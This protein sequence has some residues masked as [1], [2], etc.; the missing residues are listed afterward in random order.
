MKEQLAGSDR[1]AL[2]SLIPLASALGVGTMFALFFGSRKRTAYAVFEIFAIVSVL[3]AAALTAS[4]AISLLHRDKAISGHELTETAMPLVVAAFVLVFITVI[5]RLRAAGGRIWSLL[6]IGLFCVYLAATLTI[7]VWAATPED[8]SVVA[9]VLLGIGALFA[10]AV[11]LWERRSARGSRRREVRVLMKTLA[12]GYVPARK[13]LRLALPATE[14]DLPPKVHC[15]LLQDRTYLDLTGCERLR[16]LTEEK[17]DAM[18]EAGAQP[19]TG[20]R[21][22]ASVEVRYRIPLRRDRPE[23]RILTVEVPGGA[24]KTKVAPMNEDDLIDVT[25]LGLL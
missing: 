1:A 18:G 2:Q 23:L 9:F 3:V 22:L 14:E 4:I 11:F 24:N 5:A 6:P 19:P 7:R 15:W 8:A 16:A 21:I 25:E 10:S 13:S 20:G 17:W 12:D